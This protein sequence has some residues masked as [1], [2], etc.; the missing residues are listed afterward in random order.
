M[1]KLVQVGDSQFVV[2]VPQELRKAM[3]WEK[4]MNLNWE[5]KDNECLELRQQM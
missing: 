2:T 4:G 1:V 5:V 3:N